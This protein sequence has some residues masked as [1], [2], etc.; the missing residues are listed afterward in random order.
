MER[1]ILIINSIIYIFVTGFF[2]ILLIK[3]KQ[4]AKKIKFWR[5]EFSEWL[6]KKWKINEDAKKKKLKTIINTVESLGSAIILVLI[7]QHFYIGNFLVPT[8]SMAPTIMPKDRL[9]GNMVVYRFWKP[10]REDII[11]FKEPLQN[12]VLYTKRL[13]GLPGERVRIKADDKLYVDGVKYEKRDYTSVGRMVGKE[14]IVPRKGDIVEISVPS[15]EIDNL[16][17]QNYDI[18]KMQKIMKESPYAI[19]E[20]LPNLSFM[21]NGEETGYMLDLL[22]DET[23]LNR[24]MKGETVKLK[25][26]QDY[27]MVLGD[28][29]DE[30][31]DSRFWGFVAEDRIKGRPF[32][33]FW[34][35]NRIGLVK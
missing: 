3:E 26:K 30:S 23:I 10:E 28:N 18:G 27:Y 34:P 8:Q 12:K 25:L 19:K 29:T 17:I 1:D 9:F 20:F 15:W 11:V 21:V 35:L 5:N 16:K 24:V 22:F 31:L 6:I 2:L 32:I 33:R 4:I 13:M 14:W 7:I